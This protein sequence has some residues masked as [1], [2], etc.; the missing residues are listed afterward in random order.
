MP[1]ANLHTYTN[2]HR[3]LSNSDAGS[4]RLSLMGW[5][6]EL[7]ELSVRFG[8]EL[9]EFDEAHLVEIGYPLVTLVTLFLGRF[10]N[11]K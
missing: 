1:N 7:A 5:R 6:S 11:V 9:A 10:Y 3:K 4:S 2:A 8:C